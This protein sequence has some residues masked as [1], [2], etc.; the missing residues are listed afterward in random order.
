MENA[1]NLDHRVRRPED[2][3]FAENLRQIRLNENISLRDLGLLMTEANHPLGYSAIHRIE[4]G[5]RTVSIGELLTLCTVLGT[6]ITTM[7]TTVVLSTQPPAPTAAPDAVTARRNGL[8]P[9]T[10]TEER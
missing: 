7:T 2:N 9:R 3:Q 6:D 8:T 4:N 5:H 1:V 10:P